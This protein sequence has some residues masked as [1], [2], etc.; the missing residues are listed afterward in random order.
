MSEQV[1]RQSC[2]EQRYDVRH[3]D[4]PLS[5]PMSDTSAWDAHP[6]VFLDVKQKGEIACPYCGALYVLVND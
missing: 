5:C 2:S 6:R 1:I 4:L 3:S